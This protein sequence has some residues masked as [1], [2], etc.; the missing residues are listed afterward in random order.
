[1]AA[2]ANR[3]LV[4]G[5]IQLLPQS[6]TAPVL[7]ERDYVIAVKWLP[8]ERAALRR[9][10][11]RSRQRIFPLVEVWTKQA[12]QRDLLRRSP[13]GSLAVHIAEDLGRLRPIWFDL[14]R[15][16]DKH[17]ISAEG[18][19]YPAV[20]Y[21]FET[22]RRSGVG[23]IPVIRL[24]DARVPIQA[25]R[26]ALDI[27]RRGVSVRVRPRNVVATSV[28]PYSQLAARLLG[29]L[30]L[31]P[32][33][34]DLLIDFEEFNVGAPARA[35]DAIAVMSDLLGVGKWRNSVLM[36]TSMPKSL[37]LIPKDQLGTISR[38]EWRLWNE[39]RAARLGMPL[40]F[41]DHGI[42]NPQPPPDKS[43]VMNMCASLRYTLE[44]VTLIARGRPIRSDGIDQYGDLC[45]RVIESRK[46]LGG[47]YSW[48]DGEVER[49]AHG[50]PIPKDGSVWR[51]VGT[52]HHLHVV[53]D[54]LAKAG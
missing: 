54:Q 12:D 44:D 41:G 26:E 35:D 25:V 16:G 45:R 2:D 24:G 30:K 38:Q 7:N 23:A 31:S 9:L 42:Q 15:L 22:M 49:Y 14:P 21:V 33:D 27:D 5:Q 51:A 13:L 40:I 20:R 53:L 34:A 39:V 4:L 32:P 10:P 8:G 11:S 36:G 6:I 1:M 43:V 18:R 52:S 48:G 17:V 3:E 50:A 19:E 46:F 37:G 28:A 47:T 29:D